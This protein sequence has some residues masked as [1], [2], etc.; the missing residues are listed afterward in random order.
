[1]SAPH[2]T[3]FLHNHMLEALASDKTQAETNA[4]QEE[5]RST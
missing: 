3:A 1:M 5:A 4:T 2:N